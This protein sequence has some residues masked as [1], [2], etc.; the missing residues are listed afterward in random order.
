MSIQIYSNCVRSN[1]PIEFTYQFLDQNNN[2][3]NLSTYTAP[4]MEVKVLG[5][6]YS[7]VNGV[8]LSPAGQGYVQVASYSFP[9]G[10]TWTIQF[11]ILN[12]FSQKV[13]GS[14][15]QLTA[16]LN[17]DSMAEDQLLTC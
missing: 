6:I 10:G 12:S 16:Y 5:E 7:T 3:I 17:V 15:L 9:T 11:Y 2:V 14:P 13:Y 8:I 4:V 1:S